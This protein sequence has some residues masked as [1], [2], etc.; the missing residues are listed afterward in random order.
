[1]RKNILPPVDGGEQA[2]GPSAWRWLSIEDED[3]NGVRDVLAEV[4]GNTEDPGLGRGTR[5]CG[6]CCEAT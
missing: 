6:Y 4:R 2:E 5:R 1:L 3:A